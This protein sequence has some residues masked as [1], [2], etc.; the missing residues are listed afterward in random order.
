MKY[1][2]YYDIDEREERNYVLS[3]KNKI[4]YIVKSLE[5]ITD[6]K[7][8]I[9]SAA[10]TKGKHYCGSRKE[11]I[12]EKVSL[13]LFR[14]YGRKNKITKLLDFILIRM[15]LFFYLLSH[16]EKNDKIIVYHSL[17]YC[18]AIALAKKIKKFYLICEYEELY[19]DVSGNRR[20]KKK[21]LWFSSLA[22]AFIFP[23]QLLDSTIN[24]NHKPSVIVHGTYQVETNRNVRVF[25]KEHIHCIY[26][27]TF[28]PRKGGCAAAA[29][30][31]MFLPANYHI[32]IIG[33]G[34]K[35]DTDNIRKL[36]SEISQKSKAKVTY[37]G[38]KSGEEYIQFLQSC[39]IGLST[40][41]PD[42][43]FNATSFPSKILSY[44]ANGL[45]VVSIRIPAIEKSAVGDMLFYY[46]QQTPEEI[47]KAILS[48]NLQEIYDSREK[49]QELN[50]QFRNDLH[51]MLN[52]VK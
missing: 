4:D 24:I 9:I 33:F 45:H 39:D 26:A 6:E 22:D 34:S 15:A 17:S 27:G 1:I 10:S 8:E 13:T 5:N 40:Q 48:V 25:D 49:I 47:A 19:S 51:T 14:T 50:I 31:A 35:Q 23:T 2:C 36:I 41:N 52:I 11:K 29:T 16:V 37:D 44:L 21:E 42:A 7:I 28:D 38:L 32:H 43:T 30:A 3:A 46:E 20:Q 12:S 18:N